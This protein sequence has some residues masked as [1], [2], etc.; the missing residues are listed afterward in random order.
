LI[1][2][3]GRTRQSDQAI[4]WWLLGGATSGSLTNVALF[5]GLI[6]LT[7][8]AQALSPSPTLAGG[9]AS[10]DTKAS[11]LFGSGENVT[12]QGVPVPVVFGEFVVGSVVI[13]AGLSTEELGTDPTVNSRIA[14]SPYLLS[15]QPFGV[16]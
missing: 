7:G 6:A 9:T 12:V 15:G 11:F 8:V 2:T 4:E 16:V 1:G 10:V 3:A 14:L 13:S 5:G